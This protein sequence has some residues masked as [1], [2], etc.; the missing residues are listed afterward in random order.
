MFSCIVLCTV[1][2]TKH[3]GVSLQIEKVGSDTYC[4]ISMK[5]VVKEK[6]NIAAGT[7]AQ[8]SFLDCPTEEVRLTAS[9]VIG[10]MFVLFCTIAWCSH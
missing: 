5:S 6:I 1:D 8:L 2:L 7:M 3:Q 9:Q 10:K 4:E